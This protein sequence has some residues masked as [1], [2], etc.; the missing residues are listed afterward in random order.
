[1]FPNVRGSKTR[2]YSLRVLAQAERKLK[3]EARLKKEEEDSLGQ[4]RSVD[5]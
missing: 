3:R 2:G 5:L 4:I 1:M